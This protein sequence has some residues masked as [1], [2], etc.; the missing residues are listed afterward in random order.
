V[1]FVLDASALIAFLRNEE[2]ADEVERVLSGDGNRCF[3]HAINLCEVY[4]DFHRADAARLAIEAIN[5][6]EIAG[7][8]ERADLDRQFWFAAGTLK[9]VYRPVSLADCCALALSGRLR[10]PLLTADHHE[11]DALVAQG[12]AGIRFIR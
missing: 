3:A 6:L 1:D 11:F 8:I 12:V 2:G 5:D 10:A 4:Y 7:V 9:A